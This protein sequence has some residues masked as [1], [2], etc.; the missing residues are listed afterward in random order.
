M[1]LSGRSALVVVIGGIA[2]LCLSLFLIGLLVGGV[3]R[4]HPRPFWGG[5]MAMDGKPGDGRPDGPGKGGGPGFPIPPEIRAELK[6]IL[7][8]HEGEIEQ[9][10]GAMRD[11]RIEVGK[12]LAA[13][14]FDPKAFDAALQNMQQK[15]EA[16]Q[17][18]MHDLMLEAVPKL[19]PELRQKWAQRWMAP[20][21]DMPPPPPGD[22]PPPPPPQ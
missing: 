19:K 13:E 22:A 7:A 1:T 16:M 17:N 11:A 14:P 20:R 6:D 12:A 4:E 18:L 10:R 2:S 9:A 5:P 3:W 8:P 15:G 21:G